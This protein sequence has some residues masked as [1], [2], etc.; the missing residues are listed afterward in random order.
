MRVVAE[1]ACATVVPLPAKATSV[2]QPLDVGVMGPLKSRIRGKL[3]PKKGLTAAEKR[4][5]AIQATIAA[6]ESFPNEHVI[7]SFKSAIPCYEST[8]V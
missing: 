2:C 1:Q 8:T 5:R 3:L 7:R 4:L 6:W